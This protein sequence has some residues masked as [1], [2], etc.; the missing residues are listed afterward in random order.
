[1]HDIILF[2]EELKSLLLD[3]ELDGEEK[4]ETIVE[5]IDLID[6]KIIE[7]ES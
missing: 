6:N 1:M 3:V 4:N 7:L 2:L 5:V